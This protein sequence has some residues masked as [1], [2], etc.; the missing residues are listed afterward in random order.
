ML[1][2]QMLSKLSAGASPALLDM[3]SDGERRG[4]PL[5]SLKG[6]QDLRYRG[7][8]FQDGGRKP[9]NAKCIHHKSPSYLR[10]KPE[11]L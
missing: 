10:P 8:A 4:R 9:E 3:W 1:E 7:K 5:T 6:P 2:E 11:P